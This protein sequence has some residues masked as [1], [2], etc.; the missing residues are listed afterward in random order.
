MPLY[1]GVW[2][3]APKVASKLILSSKWRKITERSIEMLQEYVT[4]LQIINKVCFRALIK[5]SEVCWLF[6]WA[7]MA[8]QKNQKPTLNCSDRSRFFI[9]KPSGYWDWHDLCGGPPLSLSSCNWFT[10]VCG[11]EWCQHYDRARR[12]GD[13]K[14]TN[15][16]LYL[17]MY[18][19]FLSFLSFPPL[20][21][22]VLLSETLLDIYV[23]F[24]TNKNINS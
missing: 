14:H 17:H 19:S 2:D 4:H 5:Q 6:Q 13:I 24:K 23:T 3:V 15:K 10:C 21:L 9:S 11:G 8:R 22:S 20:M 18:F 16:A 1:F 12:W 7:M